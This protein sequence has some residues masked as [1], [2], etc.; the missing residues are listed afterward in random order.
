MRYLLRLGLG[1]STVSGLLGQ[2]T[3]HGAPL[4]VC[5][6]ASFLSSESELCMRCHMFGFGMG[7]VIRSRFRH[8]AVA[9]RARRLR[10]A[11]MSGASSSSS[12][13]APRPVNRAR[14]TA[15]PP[16]EAPAPAE[17]ESSSSI[18]GDLVPYQGHIFVSKPFGDQQQFLVHSLTLEK[19][20][21]PTPGD[22]SLTFDS[23]GF[24]ALV[25]V[26]DEQRDVILV[27]D[28]VRRQLWR[29]LDGELVVLEKAPGLDGGRPW[30]LSARMQDSVAVS[31]RFPAGALRHDVSWQAVFLRWPREGM[32][33]WWS[34][35]AAYHLLKL[36][37]FKGVASKWVYEGCKA[38][39]SYLK[40]CI[41][42]D[43]SHIIQ[44][45]LSASGGRSVV[46]LIPSPCLDFPATSTLG[47]LL[48]LV[49]WSSC[50]PRKGG[51]RD[52][53]SAA[54]AKALLE[55]IVLSVANVKGFDIEL[56]V[57]F[58]PRKTMFEHRP[59]RAIHSR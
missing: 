30:S 59:F 7:V 46:G 31:L 8:E 18:V 16:K 14:S 35:T 29:T 41:G 4:S 21:L 23:S 37:C 42:N 1:R 20:P 52:R 49:R 24:A 2:H 12:L 56:R 19:T 36:A 55:G 26:D 57:L 15:A 5:T 13:V 28:F 6:R 32:H 22:W 11:P 17:Q 10:C 53:D 47:V 51:L 27:E 43:G 48:L 39:E 58:G 45:R 3:M 33:Y 54:A 50:N 38:W 40:S 44:S 9:E 34:L 25:D